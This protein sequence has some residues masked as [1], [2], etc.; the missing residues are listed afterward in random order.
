VK[1]AGEP[2]CEKSGEEGVKINF[3]CGKKP[4]I[5]EPGIADRGVK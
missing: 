4:G 2:E 5:D 1:I 3:H